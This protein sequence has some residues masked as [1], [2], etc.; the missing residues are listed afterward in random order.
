MDT[1]SIQIQGTRDNQEDRYNASAQVESPNTFLFVVSDGMGG[2]PDGEV[3]A[4]I[5]VDRTNQAWGEKGFQ[6]TY[7]GLNEALEAANAEI[8]A[9]NDKRPKPRGPS[10][11]ARLSQNMASTAVAA[12]VRGFDVMVGWAGDSRAYFIGHNGEIMLETKDHSLGAYGMANYMGLR[13]GF[14]VENRA[15]RAQP[16]DLLLLMTDGVYNAWAHD[17]DL[18]R[19]LL[20]EK[21]KETL[22]GPQVATQIMAQVV[23]RDWKR[24]DNA[25]LVAVR[26]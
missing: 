26:F 23:G 21:A 1:G 25:T 14:M 22:T 7:D 13:H 20:S 10:D 24:Q 8:N 2:H 3:A 6:F 5:T 11:F 17:P 15:F 4:Q 16:G 19:K 12:M 9:E 18:F